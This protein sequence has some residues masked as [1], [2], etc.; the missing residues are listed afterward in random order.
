MK[1][2]DI[3]M[4]IFIASIS[5]LV[6]YVAASTLFGSLSKDAAKIKT[7]EAIDSTLVEPR[8]DIFNKNAINPAVQVQITGTGT[9]TTAGT[10]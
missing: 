7:I 10:Q 2:S 9:T 4:I 3:A 8:S 5:V 1:K 6:A